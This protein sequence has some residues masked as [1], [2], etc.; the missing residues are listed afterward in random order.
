M[1]EFETSLGYSQVLVT[2]AGVSGASVARLLRKLGVEVTLVDDNEATLSAVAAETGVD[3]ASVNKAA[4]LVAAGWPDLIVTSPGWRP[5]SALFGLASDAGIEIIGDVELA[6]RVDQAQLCGPKRTW[7]A[8]TGTNGKTTTTAM[9][10]EIMQA[11][12][13]KTGHTAQAVGNIGTAVCDALTSTERI[14][15][16]VAE[17]S[18]FQLHWSCQL[19]PSAGVLLNVAEDHLDWHGSFEA[20]GQAKARVL[21]A[22][23]PI[24]GV[25]DSHVRALATQDN[26]VGFT[27]NAPA[28][29]QVGVVDGKIVD[30]TGGEPVEI[31]PT[32][33]IE[34][35]GPAGIYDALAAT[36]AARSQ[37]VS[38]ETIAQALADFSV[39]GHR[40][41]I[42]ARGQQT[43]IDNSKAT[44]PHAAEAALAAIDPNDG[45]A[46]IAGG[47]LKGASIEDVV[48]NHGHRMRSASVIGVDG[49]EIVEALRT[50]APHV[51][52]THVT[53]TDPLRAMHLACEAASISEASTV[54]LAPA[55]ASLD[56]YTGMAQRGD[57]FARA[58]Q[59]C[60]DNRITD[61][62]GQGA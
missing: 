18:S 2:G 7:L 39:A 11:H 46:W 27:M 12:G 49:A 29:G 15:V 50:H 28:A 14:D 31:A 56:M 57:V 3:T 40:G 36:A 37:G 13:R 58:A 22:D 59:M 5:D 44:N 38:P 42:V 34:P 55:A 4:G 47:Q 16:L 20:Y 19:H 21:N 30:A 61:L 1:T 6:W 33:G 60:E 45:V 24:A 51:R 25:D 53:S 52:V 35:A 17:L 23:H 26:L 8:V 41:A 10:A 54:L 62:P 48:K 43:W 9:L 32:Q